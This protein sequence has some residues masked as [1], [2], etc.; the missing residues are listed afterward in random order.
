MRPYSPADSEATV[1][2]FLRAIREVASKDYS[3]AQVDAWA[4]V[5]DHRAWAAR[6][7]SRPTWIVENKTGPVGFADLEPKGNLDMM[8]VCPDHQGVGAATLLLAK[9][10]A[11]A[12]EKGLSRLSTDASLTAR[13]F[14]EG[15]GFVVLARQIVEK[16][17]QVLQNFRME[18]FLR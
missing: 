12:K 16:R 5:E 9:V 1:E 3:P 6:R 17:G 7:S 4:T 8:F 13:L 2:I 10:E 15:R 11:A 18:K 14:F